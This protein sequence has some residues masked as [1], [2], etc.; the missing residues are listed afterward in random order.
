MHAWKRGSLG[1]SVTRQGDGHPIVSRVR[2]LPSAVVKQEW[3]PDELIESWTL[4]E[5][6]WP[7]VGNKTGATRL[8]FAALLKFYEIEGRFPAYPEEVPGAAVDYLAGLVKVEPEA[9]AKYS[10]TDRQ[11]KRHRA[12]I[13]EAFGTRP[14]T[15]DDEQRWTGWLAAE[16]CPVET[17]R[18]RLADALVRRCR[19]EKVEP[20]AEG[21]IERVVGSALR[22]HEEAFAGET[23]AKLGPGV[24]TRLSGLLDEDGLLA[25]LKADPGPLGLDTLSAEIG[26]LGTIKTLGLPDELF[27]ETSTRLVAAWRAR[28]ARMYPSDFRACSPNVRATLLA[29][30]CWVRQTE[31]TDGLVELLTGLIHRINARAERRVEKELIGDLTSVPGKKG[32]YLRMVTAALDRT[33]ETV[34]AAVWPVVPGGE[35]TLRK[36][37][38]ELMATE[39]A[40]RE[41][42]RVSLRGSYT[43]YYRR[44]LTPLLGALRFKCNNTAYRPVMDAIE[45]LARYT[46]ISADQKHF[47]K[48]ETVPIEGLVP[49]AWL[50]AVTG[51]DGRIER[52][53]YELCVLIALREA[54]RRREIWVEGAGR[55]RDPDEDLPG[56][57][58]DIRDVHYAAIGKPLDAK[59]FVADLR[60]RQREALDRLDQAMAKGTTGGV[61][62]ITRNGQPWISVPQLEKLPE[63][64]NLAALKAEVQRR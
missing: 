52:V 21:Q 38:K 63:P 10:W 13:R 11:I 17:R 14:P 42:V 24:C 18:E 8:G 26:K 58:D 29:A 19:S 22:R 60:R 30:L 27:T 64:K 2:A 55:W 39:K 48:G 51:A 43:H 12:Q 61:R 16:V 54:L 15:E 7:L 35:Q 20:P 3:E 46:T 25:E 37:A 45:L 5:A 9:F 28:A 31:I 6:D 56:D 23:V 32:I 59:A 53:P 62:V 33:D 57:F 4:V 44:M 36:L 41:R 50:E 49:K 34:R 40:W 1:P 47:A